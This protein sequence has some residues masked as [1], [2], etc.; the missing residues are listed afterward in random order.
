MLKSKKSG[1]ETNNLGIVNMSMGSDQHMSVHFANVSNIMNKSIERMSTNRKM[2]LQRK[3]TSSQNRDFKFS[4]G[5]TSRGHPS[6]VL[7][8]DSDYED[9]FSFRGDSVALP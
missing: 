7:E 2:A 5:T 8:L 6:T 9:D 4:R 3:K 1:N